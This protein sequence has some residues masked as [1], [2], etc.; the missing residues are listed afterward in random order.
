MIDGEVNGI[1]Q[2]MDMQVDID[3]MII[4]L[5]RQKKGRNLDGNKSRKVIK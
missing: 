3:S 4:L 2:A 5:E 1:Y